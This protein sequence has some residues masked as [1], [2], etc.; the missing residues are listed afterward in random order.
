[1]AD[2]VMWVILAG[3]LVVF[4]LFTG[5][6]Y[7]L[8]I[9]IGMIAGSLVAGLGGSVSMQLIAAA[10]VGVLATALLRR[11]GFGKLPRTDAAGDPNVNIDIGQILS[12]ESWSNLSGE[13]H[14]ARVRYRGAMWDV[15]LAHGEAAE[16]GEFVIHEVRG[17]RLIVK[18]R[19]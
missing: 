1:M 3:V 13:H 11:S 9:A 12:V 16:P 8:M 19:S 18:A 17:N 2:W 10:A 7:L 6:F 4:E 15:D 14:T 5:T